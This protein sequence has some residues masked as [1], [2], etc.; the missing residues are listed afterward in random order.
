[1]GNVFMKKSSKNKRN[2]NS[3]QDKNVIKSN[4]KL[5]GNLINADIY[6]AKYI[7]DMHSTVT[8][9]RFKKRNID[10]EVSDSYNSN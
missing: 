7:G 10:I 8:K 9:N 6:E 2:D 5:K 3:L 1:M 4:S